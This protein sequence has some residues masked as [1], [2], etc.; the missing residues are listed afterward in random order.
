MWRLVNQC[1]RS[2]FYSVL[3]SMALLADYL[4]P[5]R[6]K[7]RAFSLKFVCLNGIMCSHPS[8]NDIMCSHP[9]LNDIMC[10]HPSLNDIMRS[11]PS[12]NDIICSHPSLNDIMCSH[13]SLN[14]IIC[15]HPSWPYWLTSAPQA[16]LQHLR[17]CGSRCESCVRS[18]TS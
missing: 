15:S 4:P 12:L 7:H 6:S 3:L 9:S 18:C 14:D 5:V 16:A 10:S 13:P 1:L 17:L 8:T 2:V 11:H